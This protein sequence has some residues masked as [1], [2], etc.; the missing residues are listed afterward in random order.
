MHRFL[1]FIIL[2]IIPFFAQS[3]N[4]F[5]KFEHL[6]ISKGLS[7]NH[8]T[9]IAQDDKGFMWFASVNGLN[10]YDGFD[11]TIYEH[12]HYDSSSISNDI[13]R[14][15]LYTTTG[16][17]WIGTD[18]GL[19][20][21]SAEKDNFIR[22]HAQPDNYNGLSS[23]VITSLFEDSKGNIWI[24][25]RNGGLCKYIPSANKFYTYKND[26]SNPKSISSN[27]IT[28]IVED[29]RGNL[30]VGTKTSGINKFNPQTNEF[31]SFIQTSPKQGESTV[32]NNLITNIFIDSEGTIWV[33][34]SDGIN[35]I[36]FD[37]NSNEYFFK[38]LYNSKKGKE[39]A[40]W[41][42]DILE[43]QNGKL[44]VSYMGAG[45]YSLDRESL[46]FNPLYN[47]NSYSYN[48]PP[49]NVIYQ[50][51]SGILW[52]GTY[53]KGILKYN[54]L[55]SQFN[56]YK[57]IPGESSSLG[58]EIVN[59]IYESKTGEVLVGTHRGGLSILKK[60]SGNNFFKNYK[61]ADQHPEASIINNITSILID[62]Q[63]YCWLGT[64]KGILYLP[65]SKLLSINKLDEQYFLKI[66][67]QKLN[68]TVWH[69]MQDSQG[70]IWVSSLG[71]LMRIDKY[72]LNGDEEVK[73]YKAGKTIYSL[74][75]SRVWSSYEDSRNNIWIATSKGLNRLNPKTQEISKFYHI[76][77]DKYS[78][79]NNSI[80]VI[81][82][83]SEGKIWIGTLGGGLNLYEYETNRFIPFTKAL[84]LPNNVVYGILEDKNK[85]L[86]VS[87]NR[88]LAKFNLLDKSFIKFYEADGLQ[89]NEF[90]L[91]AYHKGA[92]GKMYFG[93]IN[94]FNAFYADQIESDNYNAKTV[95]TNF[96]CYN[97]EVTPGKEIRGK[98][99]LDKSIIKTH[100]IVLPYRIK[101][102]SLRF[103]ALQYNNPE[104][105]KYVYKLDGF[106][107]TWIKTDASNRI[108]TYTNLRPGKYTFRVRSSGSKTK[109]F[110][111]N[112]QSLKIIIKPPIYLTIWFLSI[113]GL[114]IAGLITYLVM[115]RE[116]K[117]IKSKIELTDEVDLLQTL[118]D[119][120]PDRI[121]YKDTNSRFIRINQA[122]AREAGL[123][124][125]VDAIGKS[126]FDYM[127]KE[128]ARDAYRDELEILKTGKPLVNKIE[129]R[130]KENGEVKWQSATKVPIFDKKGKIIGTAGITRNITKQMEA[131]EK[132]RDAKVKAEQADQLKSTFLA[133]MSHEIRTPMNAIIGFSE[134]LDEENIPEQD[135]KTY[136]SYIQSNGTL[137]LN[138]INDILDIAKIEANQMKIQKEEFVLNPIL[139]EIQETNMK[140][141]SYY[142]KDDLVTLTIDQLPMDDQFRVYTD[143]SR[144][145]QILNNLLSNAVKY[146]EEGSISFGYS[147]K[148][149]DMLE[150][151]VR[152]TGIG[153]DS[154]KQEMIFDR[155]SHF[156]NR[157][158]K[159]ITGT[160]LGLSIS[161][162]LAELLGGEIRFTSKPGIGSEF[163]FTI[164]IV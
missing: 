33:G 22:F 13:I 32:S 41:V 135:K 93:G 103:A 150:F 73:Y 161:K 104:K 108:A 158:N 154:E 68:S 11:I 27:S 59:A 159:S 164:K 113:M 149:L 3:N 9:D 85:S 14:D 122:K 96:Y 36:Y 20:L 45:L 142:K 38:P 98:V 69:I 46:Q 95:I 100:E 71:S 116:K 86:W 160:G 15:I 125:P 162:R 133:N 37:G 47:L 87:T 76:P 129:K 54:K 50:D 123:G 5:I 7:H 8:I 119:N 4:Q 88:G 118:M 55:H 63:N 138:L 34:T 147:V 65:L 12:N 10:K 121:Y 137:L 48:F 157:F 43:D 24:G 49:C 64:T 16:Q 152:D 109:N 90:K 102:F 120:I 106:D 31:T 74:S 94:G 29:K 30:W 115:N 67:G 81:N 146:T 110:A 35:M 132:L 145:R 70:Y 1:L 28:D 79:S 44:W 77:K 62:S 111:Q 21:Y 107:R 58:G 39:K 101:T 51:K 56:H 83:D 114:L 78:L 97:K 105:S 156:E 130:Q 126:D 19:N 72:R 148:G 91:G 140:L 42:L 134:L 53:E 124:S 143:G 80:K 40:N 75:N 127:D 26:A 153:I 155:F 128:S 17:L 18:Y 25:T 151:Y 57:H 23:D 66:D 117:L 144:L 99:I 141:L 2:S 82:E 163:F 6:T 52:F 131:E 89:S 92:S 60:E 112:E 61:L 139:N 136:I 84:G